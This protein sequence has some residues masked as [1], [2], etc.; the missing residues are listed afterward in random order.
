M[1]VLLRVD[2]KC[3]S[4]YTKPLEEPFDEDFI[5][6]MNLVGHALCEEIQGAQL[7]FVQ[8]DEVSV[9]IHGYKKFNS[10]S[11][12]DN[13]IQKMVGV[14]ASVAGSTMT[15]YSAR[16]FSDRQIHP[17]YFDSRVWILPEAEV[18]NYFHHRQQDIIRNSTQMVARHL[19]SHKELHNKNCV[20]MREMIKSKDSSWA[21]ENLDGHLQRG[22]CIIKEKHT[23]EVDI[24]GPVERSHWVTDWNIPLFSE[25]RNY[26]EKY[27]ELEES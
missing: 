24:D 4:R 14:S 12:F 21:W 10:Q 22:R 17:A 2:G 11:W 18:C 3:F 1:P 20:E 16:V 6:A 25:D 26:I 27:L 7:A 8:S 13:Q 23:V 19:F 15:R 5:D 9:L